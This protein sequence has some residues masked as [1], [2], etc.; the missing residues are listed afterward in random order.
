MEE[1]VSLAHPTFVVITLH[2]K[3]PNITSPCRNHSRQIK[4]QPLLKIL[5]MFVW[6]L[7]F[8]LSQLIVLF[9]KKECKL[10]DGLL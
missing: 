8:L 6:K 5:Q 10:F 2:G 3:H 9:H 1:L 7:Y 4:V